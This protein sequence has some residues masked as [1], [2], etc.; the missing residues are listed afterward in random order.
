M[1]GRTFRRP[2]RPERTR[3]ERLPGAAIQPAGHPQISKTSLNSSSQDKNEK[4]LPRRCG[5]C[6]H[7]AKLIRR[8]RKRRCNTHWTIRRPGRI[9]AEPRKW[10]NVGGCV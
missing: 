9:S 4:T 10:E 6:E 1:L 5:N 7:D 8:Y 2:T 3:G